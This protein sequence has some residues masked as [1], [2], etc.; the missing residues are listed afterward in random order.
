[1]LSVEATNDNFIVFGFTWSG[2]KCTIYRHR[3]EHSKICNHFIFN[4]KP[5]DFNIFQVYQ[6][7]IIYRRYFSLKFEKFS[8]ILY[9]TF[10]EI[11][12]YQLPFLVDKSTWYHNLLKGL[13]TCAI[14]NSRYLY[15][16]G[17]AGHH[18][19]SYLIVIWHLSLLIKT[20]KYMKLSHLKINSYFYNSRHD[21]VEKLLIWHKTTITDS[22]FN[23]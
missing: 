19:L 20:Y 11:R 18:T 5:M 16:F 13:Q 10:F 17:H 22:F 1:M 3:G 6:Y 2:F 21:I 14:K 9:A 4:A 7:F 15:V 8:W 23:M 12:R